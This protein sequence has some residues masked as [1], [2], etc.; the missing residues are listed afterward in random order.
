MA[1][2]PCLNESESELAAVE[3]FG[4]TARR[5]AF[6]TTQSQ[7]TPKQIRVE[8][9]ARMLR[10]ETLHQG[11][12]LAID[13]VARERHEDIGVRKIA[14]ELRNLVFQ[15]RMIA[16]SVPRELRDDPMILM[17]VMKEMRKNETRR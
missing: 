10:R 4:E 11:I 5:I 1:I 8:P 13:Q 14:F 9:G 6:H 15:D 17:P 16:K 12:H 3:R 2:L 7:V